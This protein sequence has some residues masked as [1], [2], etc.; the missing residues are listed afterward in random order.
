MDHHTINCVIW[1]S[2]FF[3]L[4]FASRMCIPL[5]FPVM[6]LVNKI[7]NYALHKLIQADSRLVERHEAL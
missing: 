4:F 1:A 5:S 3:V 6:F 2:V 7:L